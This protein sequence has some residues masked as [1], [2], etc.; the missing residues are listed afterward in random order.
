M[1]NNERELQMAYHTL[2][3]KPD[4]TLEDVTS[5]HKWLYE[6]WNPN[7]ADPEKTQRSC[8]EIQEGINRARD[9]LVAY[10]NS[11]LLN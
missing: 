10:L 1:N 7:P 9:V 4:Y 8:R 5:Q 6:H 11:Q 3:L 2:Y